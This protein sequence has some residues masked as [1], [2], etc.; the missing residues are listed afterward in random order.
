MTSDPTPRSDTCH[1]LGVLAMK[2]RQTRDEAVRRTIAVEYG[3]EVQ[4][5]IDAGN[6]SEAPAFEYQLPDE[7]MPEAFF[8]Y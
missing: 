3:Q 1:L 6:W 7:W 5:L 2:F 4:R 8:A